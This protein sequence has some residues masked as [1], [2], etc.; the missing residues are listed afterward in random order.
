MA[1]S[2]PGAGDA[3]P[4]LAKAMMM[5]ERESWGCIM[6]DGIGRLGVARC[7]LVASLVVVLRK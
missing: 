2:G 3:A 7:Y 1:S 4:R 5:R 6:T